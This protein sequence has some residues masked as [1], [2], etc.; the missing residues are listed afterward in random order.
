M[1]VACKTAPS[2]EWQII[3]RAALKY[4]PA[5]E[6]RTRIVQPAVVDIVRRVAGRLRSS[7]SGSR[8]RRVKRAR[9][10]RSGEGVAKLEAEPARK[11]P[12]RDHLQ[13]VI[14]RDVAAIDHGY[15]SGELR[16]WEEE[17]RAESAQLDNRP[18]SRAGAPR[19]RRRQRRNAVQIEGRQEQ[20]PHFLRTRLT[21]ATARISLKQLVH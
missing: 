9:V 6:V 10:E 1:H 21:R 17:K 14:V 13:A 8:E 5:I 4:V 19:Q 11:S 16:V 2:A 12:V 15:A 7:R 3:N 18:P 20:P